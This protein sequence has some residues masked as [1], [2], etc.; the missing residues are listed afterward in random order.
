MYQHIVAKYK[1][2]AMM[3]F[4]ECETR[5]YVKVNHFRKQLQKT[6]VGTESG[7]IEE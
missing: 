6:E 7:D 3:S 4:V 2:T 1:I 5:A